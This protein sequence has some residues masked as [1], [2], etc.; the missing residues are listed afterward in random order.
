MPDDA[1]TGDVPLSRKIPRREGGRR[2]DPRHPDRPGGAIAARHHRRAKGRPG[3]LG[4]DPPDP[5]RLLWFR[6]WTGTRSYQVVLLSDGVDAVRARPRD[7]R[8]TAG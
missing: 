4:P 8:R 2:P 3:R 6:P 5:V 1:R 7:R